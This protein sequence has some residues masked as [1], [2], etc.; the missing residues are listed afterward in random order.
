MTTESP[1]RLERRKILVQLETVVESLQTHKVDAAK[2]RESKI[3]VEGMVLHETSNRKP[4]FFMPHPSVP[5]PADGTTKGL[6]RVLDREDFCFTDPVDRAR[7]V[8][9]NLL[10]YTFDW[11]SGKGYRTV[12]SSKE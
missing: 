6:H 9:T 10:S 8:E 12:W 1:R 3:R 4:H 2:L 5:R 11:T 7:Q